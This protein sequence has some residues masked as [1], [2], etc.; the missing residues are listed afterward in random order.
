MIY[1]GPFD[2]KIVIVGEAPGAEEERHKQPF[3]GESGKELTKMLHEAGI[4]RN[5]CFITNV[6]SHRPPGNNI[7][8]FFYSKREAK[9]LGE[10]PFNGQYPKE[11][12][13]EGIR[14]LFQALETI[15]PNVILALGNTPLW[16]LCGETGITKWRG[17]ILVSRWGKIVPTF[18]PADILRQWNHRS[19]EIQDFRRAKRES[20]FPE[21]RKPNW[22]FQIRP[23]FKEVKAYVND[24]ERR[25][26]RNPIP[27]VCDIE[28][29]DWQIACLGLA[30]N[31]T[32]A[33]CVPFITRDIPDGYWNIEEEAEIV[34][35]LRRLLTNPNIKVIFQ[36]GLFD[37][38]YF[39]KQWGYIPN[40]THDTM[41]MQHV[42]F[43]GM[44]GGRIDSTTGKV[45]K[46]GSSLALSFLS[47]MYCEYHRYWKDDGRLFDPSV[48]VEDTL[49][50]YNCE[51]CVRTYEC[52][53]AL[54]KALQAYKLTEQ[55]LF[56]MSL[57]QPVFQMMMRGVRIDVGRRASIQRELRSQMKET[58]TWLDSAAGH[59]FNPRSAPQMKAFFYNDLGVKPILHRKTKQPTLDDKALQQIK[60]SQPL[61]EPFIDKIEEFRSLGVF[62]STFAEAPLDFDGRLRC[63]FN[64]A[65]VETFRFSSNESAFG[66][67]TNLQNIPKGSED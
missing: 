20:E 17:S 9:L 22:Q 21:I 37:C 56:E 45:G 27:L 52:F 43:P 25:A 42:C 23:S 35:L 26:K 1:S 8:H 31:Q 50:R 32:E 41:V 47:S 15:K 16:T 64:I 13:K 36:N 5:E 3:I 46:K 10:E 18:H 39:A 7:E 2:A 30:S 24:L 28:T 51:D 67:G 38:Q 6:T 12:I 40:F 19:V 11:E 63:A 55:Y 14:E 65:G 66:T 61:L 57:F 44:L 49:W 34:Q 60:K 4:D 62:L 29:R 33:I 53:A 54:W 59:P 58:G 48:D